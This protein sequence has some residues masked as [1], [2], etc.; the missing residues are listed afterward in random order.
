MEIVSGCSVL[1]AFLALF[2]VFVYLENKTVLDSS[3]TLDQ[4]N[5]NMARYEGHF[6][7]TYSGCPD[8]N[9]DLFLARFELNSQ[10]RDF[11]ADKKHLA[12]SLRLKG[13]AAIWLSTLPN[14]KKD[15]YDHLKTAL[16]ENFQGNDMKW[17]NE[18][19]LSG[20]LQSE[21]ESLDDYFS[22]VFTLCHKLGKSE[23]EK[24][25]HFI[26]GLKPNLRAFVISKEPDTVDK[27]VH[28]A[29]L[30]QTVN[31]L[32][33]T[34]SVNLVS[35]ASSI[36]QDQ[37]TPSVST[38]EKLSE[39]IDQ[40]QAKVDEISSRPKTRFGNAKNRPAFQNYAPSRGNHQPTRPYRTNQNKPNFAPSRPV[41]FRCGKLGHKKFDCYS[42][43]H[44]EG[45]PLN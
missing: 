19:K 31:N 32:P 41:C 40:I 16:L 2:Q 10:L 3:V 11:A 29:R 9:L 26:C 27:A 12:L 5:F 33:S 25:T 8:E 23:E 24:L 18:S 39:Q 21:T 42:R 37:T 7:D 43:F 14:G 1:I 36:V 35:E 45:Y 13:N 22:D 30:A 15:T 28:F 4:S 17:V 20:R 44:I 38:I 6:S 34:P